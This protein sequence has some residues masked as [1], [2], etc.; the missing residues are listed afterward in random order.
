MSGEL[1]YEGKA[2]RVYGSDQ[3][4]AVVMEFKDDATAFNGKKRGQIPQKGVINR[5]LTT[6]IYRYLEEHRIP[7]HVLAE[8]DD[9]RLLVRRLEMI[10]LEVVVRNRVAGS[11]CQRTG[12]EEGTVLESPIVEFYF[13]N[14]RLGDPLLND[15]HILALNL[16]DESTIHDLRALA[17][18]VNRVLTPFLFERDLILVD[19][20]LEFGR[21]QG[22]LML[23]DEISPDTCR[24]WDRV[25]LNKLDKDRFRRD[26]G[27]VEEAYQEVWR[28]VQR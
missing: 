28:R 25:S 18:R 21:F 15:D 10:S 7:T 16:A 6:R 1:L 5:A 13:K 2:K 4:D 27:D 23:G 8:I 9:R 26:L 22:Q 11:L 20:K 17:L 24:L 12:L 19:F 14:D 3:E